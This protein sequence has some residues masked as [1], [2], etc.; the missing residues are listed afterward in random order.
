MTATLRRRDA[1]AGAL[2]T[3]LLPA[4]AARPASARA[5]D[6]EPQ[7]RAGG[8]R[9]VTRGAGSWLFAHRAS[10]DRIADLSRPT[11]VGWISGFARWENICPDRRG[12]YDWSAFDAVQE[13]AHRVGKP[14]KD[15][16]ILGT[17]EVGR[18]HW[19]LR[20]IPA[21]DWVSPPSR[22]TF[23]VPWSAR[24]RPAGRIRDRPRRAI[25]RR[26]AARPAPRHP[27]LAASR[28]LVRRLQ[29]ADLDAEMAS[30]RRAQCDLA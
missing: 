8:A 13:A 24:A 17:L 14:W 15:M 23:P 1:L 5:L 26:P 10:A 3:L 6:D 27:R 22:G 30:A 18:P 12:R 9:I 19:Q 25:R 29:P 2:S 7:P 28:A 11:Y 16:T 4:T 21:A 20:E